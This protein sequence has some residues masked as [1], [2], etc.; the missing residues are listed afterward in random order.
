MG[1]IIAGLNEKGG[2]AKTNTIKNLSIGLARKGKKVLVVDIDPSANL[3]KAL[4]VVVPNGEVGA[5]CN[6]LEKVMEC[7][8]IPKGY[9]IV[10]QDEGIDVISSSDYLHTVESKIMIS[11][12]R[13]IVLR[14]YI[15]DYKDDY[16]YI[17][18]DCPAGIGIFSTNALFCAD[19]V[20][21][22]MA[23][24]YLSVESVQ[25]IFKMIAQVRK[26]N[27][28]NKK[29]EVLGAVF[30]MVRNINNDR[31]IMEEVRLSYGKGVPLFN[32]YIP[33]AA[34]ISEADTARKSIYA[35][36]KNS[37]SAMVYEDLVEEFLLLDAQE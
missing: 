18:L 24:Q 4:G 32:T 17:F 1:K 34:K 36:A 7:E 11:M 27:G 29:P 3:T 6:I 9:G 25:N 37:S 33:L 19:S 26:M 15:Y 31:K 20:I 23:P 5:I 28:T 22:P 21:I 12:Q 35:H 10:H 30:T 16:D 8:D 2:V 14:K 13:E